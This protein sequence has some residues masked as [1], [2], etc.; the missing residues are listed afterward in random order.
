MKPPSLIVRESEPVSV[1]PSDEA[2]LRAALARLNRD[3]QPSFSFIGDS[4]GRLVPQHLVG[5]VRLKDGRLVSVVPNVPDEMDWQRAVVDLLTSERFAVAGKRRASARRSADI[6]SGLAETYADR[7]LNAFAR[8][9]A[10]TIYVGDE[11][12]LSTLRGRLRLSDYSRQFPWQRH[13][14]PAS[15]EELSYDNAFTQ[16]MSFVAIRLA[17]AAPSPTVSRELRSLARALRAGREPP[18]TV[19]SAV[20]S[21]SLP[22][23]WRAFEPAWDIARAVLSRGALLRWTGGRHGLEVA[24]QT[25]PLLET[26]LG[27][28]LRVVAA[29]AHDEGWR[30]MVSPKTTRPFLRDLMGERH[31]SV[32]PDGELTWPDGT[33]A[34]TFEAKDSTGPEGTDQTWPRRTHRFQAVATAMARDAPLAVLVYPDE[35]PTVGWNVAGSGRPRRLL[36]VGIGM[37]S[38]IAGEGERSRAERILGAMKRHMSAELAF[39]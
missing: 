15:F 2:L 39:R 4:G 31:R 8:E 6:A 5:T 32:E 21:R 33:P 1:P 18:S 38:Y 20:A 35:F 13:V 16:A 29:L 19:S 7:L 37:Y 11:Q 3:L 12:T 10:P 28:V 30:L 26:L 34:A 14:F 23:Q 27:R 25:W 9:G 22:P 36:A 24:V 17:T